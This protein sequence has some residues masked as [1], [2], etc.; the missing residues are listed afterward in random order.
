MAKKKTAFGPLKNALY[1][2]AELDLEVG[3]LLRYV[4][5][6]DFQKVVTF[7]RSVYGD[8]GKHVQLNESQGEDGEPTFT[9]GIN[10]SYTDVDFRCIVVMTDARWIKKP[11]GKK[12]LQINVRSRGIARG[13]YFR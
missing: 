6:D 13:G 5:K 4:T 11:K 7:F 10:S 1:P 2:A 9:I 3:S 12:N 8:V